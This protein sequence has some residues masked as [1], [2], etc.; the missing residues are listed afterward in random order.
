MIDPTEVLFVL[1]Q[2]EQY[3]W[4]SLHTYLRNQEYDNDASHWLIDFQGH[5]GRRQPYR[6][7]PFREY[8]S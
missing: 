1:P 5:A 6:W 4:H 8:A 3:G 7:D 2:E